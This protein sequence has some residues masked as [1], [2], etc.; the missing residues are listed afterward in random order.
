MKSTCV[1]ISS[2]PSDASCDMK[3]VC[4]AVS[5]LSLEGLILGLSLWTIYSFC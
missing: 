4:F 1:V 5:F 3:I 2:L